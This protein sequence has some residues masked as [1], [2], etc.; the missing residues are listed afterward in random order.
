[1]ATP[2]FDPNVQ[3]NIPMAAVIQAAQQN[4]Q[5]QLEATTMGNN[6]LVQ[7]LQS[8]GQVG[9]GLLDRRRAMA[10]ALAGAQYIAA[11]NPEL[12]QPSTTTNQVPVPQDQTASYDK[13]TGM[14]SP[15]TGN[16][17]AVATRGQN[18]TTQ[19][20]LDIHTMATALLGTPFN[21]LLKTG[22]EQHK[23]DVDTGLRN[24]EINQQGQ[25]ASVL[26]GIGQQKAT[27]EATHAGTEDIDT[28]LQ[29][30]IELTKSLPGLLAGLLPD[31]DQA[32]AARQQIADIDTQLKA[33]GYR[34]SAISGGI[35]SSG[36]GINSQKFTT[37]N[38]T[39]FTVNTG[40]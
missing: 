18:V 5:R 2:P 21:D 37:S 1:M 15:N 34:G 24:K 11:K 7:G 6:S 20:P 4:A 29:R 38:G 14:L 22:F 39:R 10:Q 9:Q 35:P 26:A 12:F 30:R 17:S 25:I 40:G 19:P 33:K 3:N 8:I 28:L 16:A 13:N 23:L 32:K 36:Q 31:S 27:T